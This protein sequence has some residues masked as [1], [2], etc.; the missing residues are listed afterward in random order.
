MSIVRSLYSPACLLYIVIDIHIFEE[1][2]IPFLIGEKKICPMILLF[3]NLSTNLNQ[4]APGD[5]VGFERWHASYN[6]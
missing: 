4:F 3:R 5:D 1:S 2:S 6:K